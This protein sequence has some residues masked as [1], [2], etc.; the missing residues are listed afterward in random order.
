MA[1][2]PAQIVG[3]RSSLAHTAIDT[4]ALNAGLDTLN[5]T[6]H[7]NALLERQDREFEARER[8]RQ[9]AAGRAGA[10][11]SLAQRR[12]DLEQKRFD[13]N[14]AFRD[15]QIGLQESA[16]A[17]KSAEKARQRF[18]AV[19]QYI[20]T[21]EDPEVRAQLWSRVT[22]DPRV[23]KSLTEYGLELDD[24]DG[25]IGLMIAEARGLQDP[26]ERDLLGARIG[27]TDAQTDKLNRESAA[28]ATA[29]VDRGKF[30]SAQ[31][32]IKFQNDLAKRFTNETKSFKD[33][34][35]AFGRVRTAVA[36]GQMDTGAADLALVFSYMKMLDPGS[37]V[38]ETEFA[39]AQNS[40]GVPGYVR[41]VWNKLR[42]GQFLTNQQRQD[43]LRLATDINQDVERRFQDRRA[44]FVRQAIEA[45]VDP[46]IVAPNFAQFGQSAT[47]GNATTSEGGLPPG[48]TVRR[49]R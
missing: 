30:K 1:F 43:F 13:A 44:V 39:N 26:L 42:N 3:P 7:R 25:G 5:Q 49:T 21:Q 40:A 15:R 34:Q 28:E 41:N 11:Q 4:R 16:A 18:G 47:I 24:V 17:E 33:G 14:Q 10:A 35:E 23:Q 32:R 36:A 31:D 20:G 27:L 8:A 48:V 22:Q 9:A 46:E 2:R 45:G 37:V 29:S 19:A 6:M 38:R 12:F